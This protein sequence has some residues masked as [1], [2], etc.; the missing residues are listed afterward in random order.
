MDSFPEIERLLR[1]S[2]DRGNPTARELHDLLESVR[3]IA[4]VGL[5]RFPE[6]AARR[7][8]S[9]MAAKG[10]DVVPVNPNAERLL[11]RQ[12]YARL[13][14]VPAAV[15][16]VLVFRPSSEAGAF[17]AE[18]MRRPER[19]AIWLQQGIRAD[20]EI[21]A[22]RADDIVA[23]QDLCVFLVHRALPG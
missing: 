17:V 8:P 6:K 21:G 10:Y 14:D 3:R 20:A 13:S 2:S 16:L 1:T 7:V 18:A 15:D 4:V 22:A 12:A 19:P 5:S 11:G 23:V 9:Y